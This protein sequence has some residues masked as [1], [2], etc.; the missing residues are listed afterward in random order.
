[1]T[2]KEK[3]EAGLLYNANYDQQL[4]K[5]RIVCKDLCLEYNALKNS[6]AE[7]RSQLL[8]KILGTT[9][10]NL[11]IEPSFWCDYGYNIEVVKIFIPII[12]L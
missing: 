12:T 4:I 9:K 6:D 1:M 11:C 5:E 3:C 8:K 2:E 10:E 7:G